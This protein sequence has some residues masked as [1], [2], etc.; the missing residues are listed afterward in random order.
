M[1]LLHASSV[2]WYGKL[3]TLASE[4]GRIDFSVMHFTLSPHLSWK[5]SFVH[6]A[7]LCAFAFLLSAQTHA[8]KLIKSV[9]IFRKSL[10]VFMFFPFF[11]AFSLPKKQSY[12]A[13]VTRLSVLWGAAPSPPLPAS[14]VQW[15][16]LCKHVRLMAAD[17]CCATE[18][19]LWK[20]LYIPP[21]TVELNVFSHTSHAARYLELQLV[22]SLLLI[23]FTVPVTVY[24]CE[25][26]VPTTWQVNCYE[27]WVESWQHA[28]I[29]LCIY[30]FD[31]L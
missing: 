21:P 15:K 26:P 6:F 9:N 11:C 30:L 13:C 17:L 31:M 24:R 25:V 23:M 20:E 3:L 8:W 5:C 2:L 14:G 1:V 12:S 22:F 18:T 7:Y 19:I 28:V 29:F 4:S 27:W 10:S 16:F